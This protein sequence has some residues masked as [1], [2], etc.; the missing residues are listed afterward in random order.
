MKHR[1]IFQIL[2]AID[3]LVNTLLAGWADE[4]ISARTYRLRERSLKWYYL[5]KFI[6]TL[7][8]FED[9][10]WW[11]KTGHFPFIRHCQRSYNTERDREQLPLEYRIK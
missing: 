3:Q 10:W 5:E 11:K 7:F 4:T 9:L 8:I 2:I 6:N 1:Y